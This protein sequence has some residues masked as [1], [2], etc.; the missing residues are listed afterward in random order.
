MSLRQAG[1]EDLDGLVSVAMA[2][3][4][5]GRS[6]AGPDWVP[7]V[8]ITERRLWWERLRDD[9]TWVAVAKAGITT[10]GAVAVWRA[11]ETGEAAHRVAYLSGPYVDPDWWGEGVG[12]ALREEAMSV[13][14]QMRCTSAELVVEAGNGRARR[15]LKANGWRALESGPK[16]SQTALVLYG[17]ALAS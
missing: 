11:R 10:V 4:R 15:F 3:A 5:T 16:R 14:R 9:Y 2:C 8:L 7:P 13:V 1:R 6:W 12:R 17:R